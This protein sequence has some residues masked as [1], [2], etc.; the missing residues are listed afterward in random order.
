MQ[1]PGK[2]K[3]RVLAVINATLEA[4]EVRLA[5]LAEL[6]G[7]PGKAWTDLTPAAAPVKLAPEV[8]FT[9]PR[10]G[11]RLFYNPAGTPLAEMGEE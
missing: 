11:M 7:G 5:E 3:G 8:N 1:I 9:L 4:Q 2:G 10:A 6:L